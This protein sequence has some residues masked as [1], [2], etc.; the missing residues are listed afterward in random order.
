MHAKL[1]DETIL[2]FTANAN[3]AILSSHVECCVVGGKVVLGLHLP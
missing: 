3:N 2:F 1:M